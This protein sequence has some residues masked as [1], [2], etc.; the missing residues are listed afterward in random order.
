MLPGAQN[1]YSNRSILRVSKYAH[2]AIR[3]SVEQLDQGLL[4]QESDE[5][6][7]D[8]GLVDV[9]QSGVFF[10]VGFRLGYGLDKKLEVNFPAFQPQNIEHR[11]TSS[12]RIVIVIRILSLDE[13]NLSSVLKYP[14]LVYYKYK[15]KK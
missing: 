14:V 1:N 13:D 8:S 4:G 5:H 7:S 9:P 11:W 12:V 6:E 15:R 3:F 10:C 2:R